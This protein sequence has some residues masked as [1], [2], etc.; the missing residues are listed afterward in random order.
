MQSIF[1]KCIFIVLIF[2]ACSSPRHASK[3]DTQTLD[4]LKAHI[5]YLADDKLE[6]R[7]TGTKGEELAM[8]YIIDQFKKIGLIPKGTESFP[9]SFP[10]NDGKQIDG[11]TELIINGNRLEV[12]KD[13]FPFSFCPDQKIEALPSVALQEVGMPWF[14]DLKET[15]ETNKNNPHFDLVNFIQTNY[16]GIKD[17]G[18]IAMIF[19]NTSSIDDKLAFDPKDKSDKLEIP[20][21]YVSKDV[22][23]K[24]FSDKSATLNIKLR[25]SIS[26]K[27]RVG[28][29]VIGYIDNKAATTVILGAHYDHLGYGEDGNSRSTSKEPAIH[30][31]ADDNA[32]GTAALIELARMLKSSKATNNNYLFIAFSGEELGLF[33]SKYF[34]EHPTIDLS[35]VDYMINM[36]MVGRLNDSTKVLTV[37]GYGTSPTWSKVLPGNSDK[38]L[39]VLKYDSS[40]TGPSDHTSFYRKNIPVLFYFTGLHA[41]YHKPSDDADKINYSGERIIVYHLLNLIESLNDKGKLAFLKT[42]E[43]QTTTSARFSVTMGI[44]PDYTFAGTGV[45]ADGVSDGKPAQ[46]AGLQAGDIIIQLGDYNVSSLENYMQALGKF[47]KG[48]KTKVKFKRGNEIREAEVEF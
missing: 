4:N 1:S 32:S 27:N 7:R 3:T 33:G 12:K 15:L 29:N 18:A 20:A 38:Q 40:G 42:R 23:K 46:K 14:F 35:A 24:Y 16:K 41:D 47:K 37:G 19:Y 36:D 43:T 17:R 30:N 11:V 10:V 26:E 25:T 48:E 9:Q 31:G 5:Q 44:M 28:H 2:A 13:F 8:E 22:A 34:T 6:G 45:R 21:V 39:L